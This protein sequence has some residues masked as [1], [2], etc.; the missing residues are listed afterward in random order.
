MKKSYSDIDLLLKDLKSDIE[1]VLM[2]EVLDEVKD[3]EIRHVEEDVFSAYSPSVYRRR[4]SDGLDDP[5]NIVGEVNNMVLEV[6]N[7]SEFTDWRGNAKRGKGLA[8]FV[9]DYDYPGIIGQ[10]RPFL[11]NT[12]EE[13]ENTNSVENA[14]ARGLRKR[15]YDVT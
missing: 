11:D 6:E 15:K 12:I 3:I 2:D 8:E 5:D 14:L 10:S 13:I 9:N 7:I 4:E 1:D